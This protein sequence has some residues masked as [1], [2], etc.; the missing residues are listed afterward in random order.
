MA[1]G[2]GVA[3]MQKQV[4][5]CNQ[6][7]KFIR[8]HW[9]WRRAL[10]SVFFSFVGLVICNISEYDLT[11]F[12]LVCYRLDNSGLS[13]ESYQVTLRQSQPATESEFS[14]R[15][16][17]LLDPISGMRWKDKTRSESAK[18]RSSP[19]VRSSRETPTPLRTTESSLSILPEQVLWTCSKNTEVTLFVVQLVKCTLKWLVDTAPEETQFTSSRQPSKVIIRSSESEPNNSSNPLLDSQSSFIQREH[20]LPPTDVSSPPL[21]QSWSEHNEWHHAYA[22]MFRDRLNNTK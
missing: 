21:D 10:F 11:W 16:S 19:S 18:V 22:G 14:P 7:S 13:E 17:S 15:M 1:K 4:S 20:Q 5:F 2:L 9:D 6:I 12:D 8:S 3:S